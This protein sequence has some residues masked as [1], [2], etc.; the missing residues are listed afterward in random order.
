MSSKRSTRVI[1]A[2]AR[3]AQQASATDGRGG[4]VG[5]VRSASALKKN[6]KKAPSSSCRP[7][8]SG[9]SVSPTA[10]ATRTRVIRIIVCWLRPVARDSCARDRW[11]GLPCSTTYARRLSLRLSLGHEAGVLKVT[12][13]LGMTRAVDG[14]L[15]VRLGQDLGAQGHAV[16]ADE[17]LVRPLAWAAHDALAGDAG[18]PAERAA[19]VLSTER[20][21]DRSVW[22]GCGTLRES[23]VELSIAR[24]WSRTRPLV[25]RHSAN[26]PTASS[27]RVRGG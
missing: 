13:S 1:D 23:E 25:N 20:P 22:R 19:H 27:H 6:G 3:S 15:R 14:Q 26:A 8:I 21:I 9:G 16:L 2:F 4:C 24:A 10:R 5:R 7:V 11:W 17:D 12:G 18:S